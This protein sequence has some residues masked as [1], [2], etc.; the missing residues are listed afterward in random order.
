MKA[1]MNVIIIIY[2]YYVHLRFLY[3]Q[4]VPYD[5]FYDAASIW[6]IVL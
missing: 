3:P 2:E 6:T 1:F 4:T 5:L